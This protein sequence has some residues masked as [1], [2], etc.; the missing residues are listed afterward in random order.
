MSTKVEQR[1]IEKSGIL[2]ETLLTICSKIKGSRTKTSEE[3][4]SQIIDHTINYIKECH[5]SKI[6]SDCQ[7][8]GKKLSVFS[9]GAPSLDKMKKMQTVCE[10]IDLIISSASRFDNRHDFK[11]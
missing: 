11:N 2:L 1:L 9:R 10:A 7:K 5:G 3:D 6:S 8:I 4:L